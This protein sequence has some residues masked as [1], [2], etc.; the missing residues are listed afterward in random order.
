[1]VQNNIIVLPK[2]IKPERIKENIDIFDFELSDEE[3]KEMNDL[4]QGE[5]ERYIDLLAFKGYGN[6]NHCFYLKYHTTL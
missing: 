2:S 3:M 6:H 5:D 4:D 1:M